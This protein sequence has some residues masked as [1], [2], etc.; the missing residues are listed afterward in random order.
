METK[1]KKIILTVFL[2]IATCCL[3]VGFAAVNSI[4]LDITGTIST[5]PINELFILNIKSSDDNNAIV[6][7]YD[8]TLLN[9]KIIL[10]DMD[11]NSTK[12]FEITLYNN[13][14][15]YQYFDE[16]KYQ[17]GNI[18]FDNENIDF[19]L[20]NLER[21]F[22]IAP[23]ETKTF[24][25]TF[26][27][28]DDYKES[29]SINPPSK[30]NNILNSILNF[31]F[32]HMFLNVQFTGNNEIENQLLVPSSDY[33]AGE[34]VTVTL[35]K[36]ENSYDVYGHI[37]LDISSIGSDLSTSGALKYAVVN[38]G[39]IVAS[40]TLTGLTSGSTEVLISDIEV[41]L[42]PE[43]YTVYLWLD[44][45][46]VSDNTLAENFMAVVRCESTNG[47]T[48]L[49][50]QIKQVYDI[51]YVDIE[52]N[53]PTKIVEGETLNIELSN[54]TNLEIYQSNIKINNFT[55]D[56]GKLIVMNIT[57]NIV[58]KAIT[59]ICRLIT[60]SKSAV[61]SQVSCNVNDTS[62]QI[63]YILSIEGDN[64]NLIMNKNICNDGSS[65]SS[66]KKCTLKWT[67]NSNSSTGPITAMEYLN[68]ATSSW[69]NIDKLDMIFDD[70][71]GHYS[72]FAI[73]GYARLPKYA[74]LIAV[75]CTEK[76]NSCPSW[77]YANLDNSNVGYYSLSTYPR[78][79]DYVWLIIG[80]SYNSLYYDTSH[81][82]SSPFGIR[83][84][85]TVSS[86]KIS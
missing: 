74:E 50:H 84:V 70:D 40:D 80:L 7:D 14:E 36:S 75:G 2:I 42:T 43:D 67:T 33:S 13:S 25:I 49:P 51:E 66:S 47:L 48:D 1:S 69:I 76:K 44:N 31:N 56:D 58:I 24:T 57:G 52:G 46:I 4:N 78:S 16:V 6:N 41:L 79:T 27:Y 59:P 63:F 45:D 17:L 20:N 86:D 77:L 10:S 34:S 61:G 39:L 19:V 54:I 60:G 23:K 21:D 15:E 55:F 5:T 73:N 65:P 62:T 28:S 64:V 8:L 53:Y 18:T 37:Y 83:P 71:G 82:S 30:L 35:S 32:I 11:I 12:S 81:S 68:T 85:I 26:K 22:K 29:V 3:G 38:N 9:T 72:G